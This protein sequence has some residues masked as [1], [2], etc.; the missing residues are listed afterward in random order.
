MNRGAVDVSARGRPGLPTWVAALGWI[1][2]VAL[3]VLAIAVR[4][5]GGV[6]LAENRFQFGDA[7][8]V[9]I[10]VFQISYASVGAVVAARRPRH[11]V[12]WLLLLAAF[13]YAVQMVAVF[14]VSAVLA[15]RWAP[16]PDAAWAAVVADAS[17]FLSGTA[18]FSLFFVFPDGRVP[19]A[20]WKRL[21]WWVL[22]ADVPFIA[23]LA[24]RPGELWLFP[25][26]E[27]PLA[28]PQLSALIGQVPF[29][30]VAFVALVMTGLGW[31]IVMFI[32]RAR[33][34]RGVARQQIKWF[35][36]SAVFAC[37][38]LGVATLGGA[39]AP[40]VSPV[41]EL[42]LMAFLLSAS[43]IPV[44]IGI[45]ILRYR[46]YDIDLIIRRTLIYGVLS[47]GLGVLYGGLVILLQGV[48]ASTT[49]GDAVPVAVSTL[50]IAALFQPA[51]R[52]VQGVVDRRYY[53]SR[54]DAARTVEAFS[55]RL[56][57]QVDLERL[58]DELRHVTQETMRPAGVS[59]WLRD[60]A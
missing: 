51:R 53:R 28:A 59:V 43:L 49:S 14:Y 54:Y 37:I 6:P 44:A 56:R 13:L 60:V 20:G 23:V 39:L 9:A 19:I 29:L 10:L 27:N 15:G 1:V 22:A 45:A 38:T 3:T 18:L 41:G 11:P 7:S 30:P 4:V 34:A 31:V 42:P 47:L 17:T 12:G 26:L 57:D 16:E 24:V 25:Q 40:G 8:L 55:A 5:V 52:A 46:L 32:A 35:A 21:R 36:L 50:A 58:T 48:L 33:N 2:T